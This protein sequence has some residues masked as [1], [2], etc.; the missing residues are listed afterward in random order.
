MT[1]RER[2]AGGQVRPRSQPSRPSWN[3]AFGL[4][5]SCTVLTQSRFPRDVTVHVN[6]RKTRLRLVWNFAVLGNRV[7][8]DDTPGGTWAP[9][10]P[11]LRQSVRAAAPSAI[12]PHRDTQLLSA[13]V[14]PRVESGTR[15]TRERHV[16]PDMAFISLLFHYGHGNILLFEITVRGE[17]YYPEFHFRLVQGL[18]VQQD[19]KR[20]PGR[21][22]EFRGTSWW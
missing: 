2:Q 8:D 20:L 7:T 4:S 12:R 15:V 1:S 5:D 16:R 14:N 6:Q 22:T 17:S 11:R 9:S 18:W 21:H 13:S 3:C 19:G 10:A